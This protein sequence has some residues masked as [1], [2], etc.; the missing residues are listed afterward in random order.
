MGM[1]LSLFAASSLFVAFCAALRT[2]VAATNCLTGG[3]RRDEQ[4]LAFWYFA[5][6]SLLGSASFAGLAA[7]ALYEAI[8][9]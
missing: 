3:Y 1:S 9:Y 4:P 7:F 2:G 8:V 5:G 6:I